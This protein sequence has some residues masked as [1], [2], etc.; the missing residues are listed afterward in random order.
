MLILPAALAFRRTLVLDRSASFYRGLRTCVVDGVDLVTQA[1]AATTGSVQRRNTTRGIASGPV[2]SA[3]N[4]YT[5][6]S[7][8]R[9]GEGP[10]SILV[11]SVGAGNNYLVGKLNGNGRNLCVPEAYQTAYLDTLYIGGNRMSSGNLSTTIYR[12]EV[13]CYAVRNTNFAWHIN[14]RQNTDAYVIGFYSD[15][16][17]ALPTVSYHSGFNDSA[18]YTTNSNLLLFCMWSRPLT[19]S[20]LRALTADPMRLFVA[21]QR[22]IWASLGGGNVYNF[23]VLESISPSEVQA[24]AGT[25][26]RQASEALS[27]LDA[28]AASL[29]TA[30]AASEGAI[31]SELITPSATRAVSVAEPSSPGEVPETEASVAAAAAATEAAA[32]ADANAAASV[33]AAAYAEAVSAGDAA[34]AALIALATAAETSSA[35]D[36]FSSG[37]AAIDAAVAETA[38]SVDALSRVLL[39]AGAVAATAVAGES[40]A[41]TATRPVAVAEVATALD[42]AS[43]SGALYASNLAE[44]AAAGDAAAAAAAALA[45]ALETLAAADLTAAASAASASTTAQASASEAPAATRIRVVTLAEGAS[46]T[47]A[48]SASIPANVMAALTEAAAAGD[49][50][51][52]FV[53]GALYVATAWSFALPAFGKT[54]RIVSFGKNF[55]PR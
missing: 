54:F 3:S 26:A 2:A 34:A 1:R 52:A 19:D 11:A 15:W 25:F 27:A 46:A 21:P 7:N 22:D 29:I 8:L 41:T 31:A 6:P 33:R 4:Y 23:S 12:P 55:R 48:F 30:R 44:A 5:L 40:L 49:V 45:A 38:A 28:G 50:V 16:D 37:A 14:G 35:G 24:A 39:A 13:N 36:S 18:W 47:E 17:P 32:A 20:E 51:V 53:D 42:A 43:W 9:S 10:D